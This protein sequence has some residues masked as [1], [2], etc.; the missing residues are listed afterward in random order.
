MHKV[1]QDL[2]PSRPNETVVMTNATERPKRPLLLPLRK[3]FF[4][5]IILP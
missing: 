1:L 2:R 3:S 4:T 5:D